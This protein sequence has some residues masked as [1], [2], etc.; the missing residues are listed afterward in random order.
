MTSISTSR[1]LQGRAPYVRFGIRHANLPTGIQISMMARTL[2]F[3]GILIHLYSYPS[4]FVFAIAQFSASCPRCACGGR[5]ICSARLVQPSSNLGPTQ[6][7]PPPSPSLGSISISRILLEFGLAPYSTILICLRR[8]LE[9]QLS[10]V[11]CH[12]RRF[13]LITFLESCQLAFAQVRQI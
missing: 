11:I 13:V 6:L 10:L 7:Q 2:F 1:K 3:Q 5:A 9:F 8:N 12:Q 4:V